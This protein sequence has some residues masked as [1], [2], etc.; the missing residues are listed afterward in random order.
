MSKTVSFAHL[1]V[2]DQMQSRQPKTPKQ[3]SNFGFN[4]QKQMPNTFQMRTRSREEVLER[5]YHSQSQVFHPIQTQLDETVSLND[6]LMNMFVLQETT[7]PNPVKST[8]Q[9]VKKAP[10]AQKVPQKMPRVGADKSLL[11][12]DHMS[13][14]KL[15]LNKEKYLTVDFQH[16]PNTMSNNAKY[17]KCSILSSGVHEQTDYFFFRSKQLIMKINTRVPSRVKQGSTV[18]QKSLNYVVRRFENDFYLLRSILVNTYGQCFIPP[19]S[20]AT[21]EITFDKKSMHLRERTFARF[22]R[23]LTRSKEFGSHPLVLEFLKTDHFIK[24]KIEGMKEFSK[25]LA[26]KDQD[27]QKISTY[28]NKDLMANGIFRVSSTNEKISIR[29]DF[30]ECLLDMGKN[31]TQRNFDEK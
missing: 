16:Q 17:I 24:N 9:K 13:K 22:L 6:S 11:N 20:P 15:T 23:G 14:V 4:P 5:S 21:K 18:Q 1:T 30:T 2:S 28:Y 3:M 25:R 31:I 8:I 29:E 7:R 10:V 26:Q 27:L 19:L 12:L